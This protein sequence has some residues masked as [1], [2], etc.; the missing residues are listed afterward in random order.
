M[1]GCPC[2]PLMTSLL[3]R[4]LPSGHG[5]ESHV[6][7][8]LL[9]PSGHPSLQGYVSSVAFGRHREHRPTLRARAVCALLRAE[10]TFP[11]W[12]RA[13]PGVVT[14]EGVAPGRKLIGASVLWTA[15][16]QGR[17]PCP[18]RPGLAGHLV[19]LSRD[20]YHLPPAP[21]SVPNAAQL[22]HGARR[23]V[24]CL[25]ALVPEAA[26]AGQHNQSPCASPCACVTP[27]SGLCSCDR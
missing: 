27:R 10:V 25:M 8:P 19:R 11:A 21:A 22:R 5:H 14:G 16:G 1:S 7:L 3:P 9:L 23:A 20:R 6:C 15:A 2:M 17:A 26:V 12:A 18:W 4:A 13:E 24:P